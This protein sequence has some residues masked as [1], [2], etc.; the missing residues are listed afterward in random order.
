MTEHRPRMGATHEV[1]MRR[2]IRTTLAP[3]KRGFTLIELL[4]VIAIIAI[5][6]ALLL[7]ALSRAKTKA[8]NIQ[9][10][11][12]CKQIVLS[13]VMY[14]NDHNGTLISYSDP[15]GAYTLWIGRLQTNYSQISKSR[16]CAATPDPYPAT[17]WQQK[18][19]AAYTG[20][21]LADYP[22]N[23]GVFSPANP[24][25][26]SYGINGWCYSEAN[27]SKENYQKETAITSPAKTPY[28]SDSNWVD[29]WPMET[30]TPARNLYSG[31]DNNSMERITMARHGGKGPSA[32]PRS[33]I[34]GT[35]LVGR[36]NI[37]FVD[38]H[39]EA[40]KLDNLWTLFWHKGWVTPL[41]RPR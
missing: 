31:G 38:G 36:I 6:A 4:V 25:H 21:G 32:A 8:Q 17:T 37:G 33:V 15:S 11:N 24:Y 9:C 16:I 3:C 29:G 2:P 12:N 14:V 23:W 28:F 41:T 20:F 18:P 34:P 1:N 13:M 26:G 22:W 5:L 40:V 27:P 35:P 10:V 19:E 7:P 30:D 39:V